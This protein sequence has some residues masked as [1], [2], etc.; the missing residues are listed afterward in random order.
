MHSRITCVLVAA[1]VT[2]AAG[3]R[4][5]DS[6]PPLAAGK[7]PANLDELW[8]TYD[9]RAEPLETQV[10]REWKEGG[11]TYRYVVFTTGTFKGRKAR[12]AAF[13]AFPKSD[14]KLPAILHAHGGGQRASVESV[15]YAAD[16]GYAGLSL[17]WGGNE[18]EKMEPGDPNTD[19]GALDA[20]QKHNEHYGTLLPDDRT[21]DAVESARNN[22]WFLLV[23][24]ARRGLTF[25]DQ[26]PE[27]DPKRLGVMGHSMGG[28][29][30]VDVAGIDR[31]VKAAAPSCGGTGSASGKLSGMPGSGLRSDFKGVAEH[32]IDDLAYIPRVRC[33]ILFMAPANDF[34]GPLDNMTENWKQIGSREVRYT[35]APH[36]NHRSLPETDICGILWFDQH[37]KGDFRF[38]KTPEL[39]VRLRT[40][41]GV[42]QAR[43]EPDRPAEV[44]QVHIYYSVDPHCLT[45]FWRDAQAKRSGDAWIADCP[46]LG[47]NQPLFVYANVRYAL[48]TERVGYRGSK[49]PDAFLISSREAMYSPEELQKAGVKAT[50]RPSRLIDDFAHGWADWYRLEWA[51]PHVWNATTRKL[52]DP[53]WR[54]TAGAKLVFDVK[55][56]QDNTIVVIADLNGWG[57]YPGK[58]G[59]SYLAGRALKGSPDW[60]TVSVGLEDMRPASQTCP[61]AMAAWDTVTELSLRRQGTFYQDGKEVKFGESSPGWNEP[62]EFRNLRWEGGAEPAGATG[63]AAAADAVPQ[64]VDAIIQ[65]E[66]GKSVD[67]ENRERSKP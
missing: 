41:S 37:L 15:K 54:G 29:I 40:A 35:I 44:V 56:P 61:P 17:N 6:L 30:T 27:V 5:G 57:V 60:Q 47:T 22:N 33:P 13:Y 34:A 42:P 62:R 18:M 8:G 14:R 4:A 32:T 49:A 26:Q 31:R 20:T 50:D 66:I 9:P 43:L 7:A 52:K 24:A 65:K 46:V 25:L 48:K 16:N 28:K 1:M 10:V 2:G 63:A 67:L 23:L 21:L 12:M 11:A 51:N 36:L 59:G 53:K 38:P 45:R 3:L 55:C 58:P 19:W 64:N 39:S